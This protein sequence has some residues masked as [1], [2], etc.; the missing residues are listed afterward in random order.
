M[1][2]C[3]SCRHSTATNGDA[4]RRGLER[5]RIDGVP[6]TLEH[7]PGVAELLER[8]LYRC[9]V[10]STIVGADDGCEHHSLVFLGSIVRGVRRLFGPD[11]DAELRKR[12]REGV[13]TDEAN[14]LFEQVTAAPVDLGARLAQCDF[15]DRTHSRCTVCTQVRPACSLCPQCNAK[16]IY[17][18]SPTG[19]FAW[20]CS[21]PCSNT[22]LGRGLLPLA[23]YEGGVCEGC[24]SV[25]PPDDPDHHP[26]SR[27]PAVQAHLRAEE[28]R[29]AAERKSGQ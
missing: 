23:G 13:K 16:V 26:L 12:I 21:R 22:A 4:L 1:L 18:R 14:R 11:P 2:H 10:Y 28:E 19:E 20:K 9:D 24:R 6:M 29:A 15:C 7:H 5:D 17:A 3:G 25:Q 27:E 8:Q